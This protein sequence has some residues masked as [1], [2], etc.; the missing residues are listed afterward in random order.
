MRLYLMDN[1]YLNNNMMEEIREALDKGE[2]AAY[3][4]HKLDSMA[5]GGAE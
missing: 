3:K 5:A 1:L 4:R 2:F